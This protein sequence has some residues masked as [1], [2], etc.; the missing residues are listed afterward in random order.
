LPAPLVQVRNL[1]VRYV[2]ESGAAVHALDSIDLDIL[3]GEIAGIMGE[4]GSGKSTLTAAL[5]RLLPTNAEFS[6]SLLV[7]GENLLAAQEAELRGMRGVKIALIPQDPAVSLNPV[8]RVGE[9]ISEVLRAHLRLNRKQRNQRVQELLAEVGFDDAHRIA[10]S[11]PHQL[12]G[13]QLQRIVIAQAIA[14]RPSLIIADEPTSKLDSELQGQIL[15]LL[16]DIV[17]RH[18]SALPLITHDPAILVGFA[19]RIVIM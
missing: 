18:A 2:P 15:E 14:C 13:G 3:S 9:Q 10:D 16:R 4:S 1:S 12:S 19:D 8:I 7:E 5:I 17:R 6:G 11:Y